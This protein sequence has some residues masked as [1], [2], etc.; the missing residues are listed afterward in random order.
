MIPDIAATH[1]SLADAA[2]L[3]ADACIGGAWQPAA[4]G[5][6][7]IVSNPA[8]GARVG[9][10]PAMGRI[11]ADAAVAAAEAAWPAW[12]ALPDSARAALLRR[13][14]GLMREHREDLARLIT[15]EQGKPLA[16]SRSEIDY[17]AGFPE[18][19]AGE[20]LRMTAELPQPHL[21]GCTLMISR[22]P[23]GIC[24]A[25]TPWNFPVAMITRKAGAALAAGCPIV[26]HPAEETP[27]S[28]L[29]L[30]ELANRAGLPPG[31]L[32]V[33]TGPPEAIVDAWC[34]DP[35]VRAL[36]FTGSTAVGRR[37]L[38][39]CAPTVKRVQLELGGHAPFIVFD[40]APLSGAVAGAV[41]AKF[42][43]SGQ[44]CLAANRI[45]VHRRVYARFLEEFAA[46]VAALPVGDGFAD[47]TAIGPLIHDRAIRKCEGQVADALGAGA[48]LLAG[49][50]RHA[51]GGTFFQPTVLA[52]VTP[53]MRIYREE[54][55]GPIAAV[56]PFGDGDD[57]AAM[58]N[59][60]EYG[61][62]AY[63]FTVDAAR[64]RTL[65]SRLEYGMVAVN[66]V[67]MTGAPIP[68]GGV[69]QSGLGREGSRLG[70]E[71]FTEVKYVCLAA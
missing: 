11:E 42:A 31:V 63:L 17:A 58:A 48:G 38:A 20:L 52:D 71:A 10:V 41:A 53:A 19:F 28:A 1:L 16:E 14:A 26:V 62:A 37:L 39:Q 64:I 25:V 59:D 4:S 18:W 67:K 68:F 30:A 6:T 49:G 43:T 65:V 24:A 32:S 54:T 61:L 3:R 57:I 21:P 29:A 69:K 66:R 60:S 56:I 12:R 45:Y 35:R 44:D 70:I 2:L 7:R 50:G 23:V 33:V 9:T 36:S 13:W 27:L 22:E 8:T 15:A 5:A 40:D 46:A 34:A 51:L 55:F 47:G